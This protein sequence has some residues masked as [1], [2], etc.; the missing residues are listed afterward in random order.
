MLRFL[1]ISTWGSLTWIG[2]GILGQ[3]MFTFRMILQ[4]LAS[5][6]EKRSVIPV[7]FWWGSLLG[8]AML[9]IYFIWRK[10]VVGVLGQSTG[11]LIYARNLFLIYS[12][13]TPAPGQPHR[14]DSAPETTTSPTRA[15]T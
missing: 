2:V 15:G 14:A 4:W 9:L 13:P 3:A 8:G 1:N 6:K 7:G 10:D 11:V 12:R 5:E